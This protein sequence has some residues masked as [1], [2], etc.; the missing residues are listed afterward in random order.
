MKKTLVLII[1]AVAM[2]LFAG[3]LQAEN[4]N[5]NVSSDGTCMTY[6]HVGEHTS[7][8]VIMKHR[9]NTDLSLRSDY[10]WEDVHTLTVNQHYVDSYECANFL[11]LYK[12]VDANTG[13]LVSTQVFQIRA[14]FNNS[15]SVACFYCPDPT[16]ETEK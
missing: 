12:L 16:K 9:V 2:T 7:T 4:V 6:F 3:I 13:D 15:P 8:V 1:F 5:W 11:Y 10:N 14:S